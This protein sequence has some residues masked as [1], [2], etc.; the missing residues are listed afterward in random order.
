M[1]NPF[2]PPQ[3]QGS[4]PLLPT[5]KKPGTMG[6]AMGFPAGRSPGEGPPPMTAKAPDPFQ[7]EN[8]TDVSSTTKSA[9]ARKLPD[10]IEEAI[11]GPVSLDG[12][13][14]DQLQQLKSE[15]ESVTGD[16][17]KDD[18]IA[19]NAGMD[20]LSPGPGMKGNSTPLLDRVSKFYD[21]NF[22][23]S[24][25]AGAGSFD[26]YMSDTESFISDIATILSFG[27]SLDN[28]GIKDKLHA[29]RELIPKGGGDESGP[30]QAERNMQNDRVSDEL[31]KLS[32]NMPMGRM[33]L[34]G[35]PGAG[36]G[37][38]P[39]GEDS[40][41]PTPSG[42]GS[43]PPSDSAPASNRLRKRRPMPMQGRRPMM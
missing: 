41:M 16:T 13:S 33:P 23:T 43:M 32:K 7:E 36:A 35:P 22:E 9:M 31:S 34:G 12:S 30:P 27:P 17:G 37:M 40:G 14:R 10:A 2:L 6:M 26:D 18:P 5:K 25:D 15:A 8:D 38:P 19:I 20:T 11:N 42:L 29:A 28:S 39:M 1:P 4:S 3:Q 24:T 21:T